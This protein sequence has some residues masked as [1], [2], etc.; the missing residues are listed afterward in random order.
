M[1][2]LIPRDFVKSAHYFSV[3]LKIQIKQTL[4]FF[5]NEM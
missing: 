4:I 1:S 3:W 2:A 5:M